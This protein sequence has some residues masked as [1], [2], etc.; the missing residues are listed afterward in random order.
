MAE[1]S[2]DHQ[3]DDDTATETDEEP[4]PNAGEQE[5][6]EELRKQVEEEYDFEE[7]GEAQMAEI[8]PEEWEAAFD[9]D[10]WV[11][12]EALLDR[13]TN[14]LQA[15]VEQRDVFAVVE[16]DV[17]DADDGSQEVVLAYSDE[18]Y[19]VVYPNGSV[20][21]SGTVLRDV[22]PV[23]AL[24]S[25]PDY[26]PAEP[27][28]DGTLPE[29]ESVASSG[30]EL[31]NRVMQVVGIIQ[32]IAGVV[33]LVAWV[34]FQLSVIVPVVAVGFVLFGVFVLGLVAN[35]RLADRFRAEEYR[36]RLRSAG[37]GEG[38]RPSFVPGSDSSSQTATK[39]Q[40]SGEAQGQGRGPS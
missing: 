32:L 20:E 7:F 19:A 34:I 30:S 39:Q 9:P 36:D 14:D 6:A 22:K 23:V 10:T 28:G 11:T 1:E 40:N 33:L 15:K 17:L 27:V 18:G 4:V 37:V 35:A 38:D 5:L 25:M 8:S 13:V 24:C 16:R 26:E 21:G 2:E 29:P 31:G 12:G 3:V